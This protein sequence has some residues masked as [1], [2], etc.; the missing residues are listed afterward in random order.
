MVTVWGRHVTSHQWAPQ[1][2]RNRK[3]HPTQPR[4]S[5]GTGSRAG[6]YVPWVCFERRLLARWMVFPG[7]EGTWFITSVQTSY[8]GTQENLA[9]WG[10]CSQ[11]DVSGS[12]PLKL[13]TSCQASKVLCPARKCVAEELCGCACLKASS[14]QHTGLFHHPESSH[15]S[16]HPSQSPP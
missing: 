6:S 11:I 9:R 10:L 5:V 4:S 12:S 1:M 2:S 14:H 8:R 7:L 3:S 13:L 16:C 15:R